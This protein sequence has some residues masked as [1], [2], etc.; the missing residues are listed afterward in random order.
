VGVSHIVLEAS[1]LGLST[2]RLDHCKIDVGLL[3][4]VGVDHYDEHGGKSQYIDAKKR[5]F[6]MAKHVVVN[7]DDDVCVQ[8]SQASPQSCTFFGTKQE[9]EVHLSNQNGKLKLSSGNE[10]GE[11][12]LTV[13][14]EFNHMNVAAAISAL[15]V[16]GFPLKNILSHTLYLQLPEGRMQHLQRDGVTVYVDFAH[17]PD[18][19]EAVLRSISST[20]TGKLI[21][22]FGCG[23]DRDRGKRKEMGELAA[24]YSSS[25]IVT[26]DNPRNEDPL[27]IIADIMEGFGDDCNA[28]EAEPDRK[29]AIEKAISRAYSGDIVLIAGKGHEKTQQTADGV[30]PFSDQEHAE[31]ALFEKKNELI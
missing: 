24:L 16:L 23:G 13:P 26:S 4:N 28:I 29:L 2:F 7:M 11:L 31:R 27:S 19:L 30:F 5:L 25:V 9:A 17:T 6:K 10:E 21:T 8:M 18:A 3:L 14:G 1:S 15:L 20:C 12:Y 22:V